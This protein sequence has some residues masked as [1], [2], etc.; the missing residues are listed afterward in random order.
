MLRNIVIALVLNVRMYTVSNRIAVLLSWL[1]VRNNDSITYK[2][3]SYP[4]PKLHGAD[5]M[6]LGVKIFRDG[7][8]CNVKPK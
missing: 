7:T 6:I 2:D 8:K 4:A 5:K 1:I 3:R